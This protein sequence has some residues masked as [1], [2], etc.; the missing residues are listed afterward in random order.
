MLFVPVPNNVPEL[1]NPVVRIV[2][3][4]DVTYDQAL[5]ANTFLDR[6]NEVLVYVAEVLDANGTVIPFPSWLSFVPLRRW[7]CSVHVFFMGPP[8][9]F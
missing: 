3:Y 7:V 1:Q 5:P 8:K 9:R 2:W 4:Q 6:D